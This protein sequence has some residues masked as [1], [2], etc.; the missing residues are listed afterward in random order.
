MKGGSGLIQDAAG[1][2]NMVGDRPSQI[3]CM[4]YVMV[5][6]LEPTY[7]YDS[8]VMKLEVLEF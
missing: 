5:V 3:T 6:H 4:S 2:S 7:L 1:T 8:V